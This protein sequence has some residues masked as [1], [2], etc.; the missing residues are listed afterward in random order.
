MDFKFSFLLALMNLK[1]LYWKN[2]PFK[3][4]PIKKNK[5][6]FSNYAGIGFGCNPKYIA[7]ELLKCG[8]N[9]DIVWLAGRKTRRFKFPKGIRQVDYS[10]ARAM[11]ELSTAKVWVDNYHKVSFINKH[12]T[13]R[14]GQYFVQTWHGSLGIKKIEA[15][16]K[17]LIN[18]KTWQNMAIINA[19]MQDYLLSNSEF[20]DNVYKSAFWNEGKILRIGHARNDIFFKDNASVR[21]KVFSKL[22]IPEDKKVLI[23][24]PTYRQGFATDKYNVD[25]KSLKTALEK[26][27][28]ASWAIIV[29][30]HRNITAQQDFSDCD[31]LFDATYYDD[32][33]ELLAVS[34]AALTDYSSCVF[35]FMLTKRPAFIYALDI[36]KYNNE[37]GFYYSI[38]DTPF[39][40]AKNN[41]EL[42]QNIENFDESKYALEHKKFLKDKGCVD[43]GQAACRAAKLI[44]D[45][46]E[47]KQP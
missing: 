35:D 29:R 15:D 21:K 12:L 47:D 11:Y 37:R 8:K 31:Y 34:D 23:Y 4:L 2:L 44:L 43:D 9:L 13:K 5:I 14:K 40:V 46:L 25:Y 45:L 1:K 42:M 7:Q 24:V 18:N 30:L 19:K 26:R 27:F 41:F 33:Q 36:E 39:P 32:V 22:N 6:V 17:K 16:V 10:S 3:Y 28:G 38:Y 20:E